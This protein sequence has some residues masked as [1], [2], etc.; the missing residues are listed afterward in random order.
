MILGTGWAGFRTLLDVDIDQY[1]VHVVSPRNH[2]LFTPLLTSTTVG[3]LEFR[4]VIGLF[5]RSDF[6]SHYKEPVRT[7]RKRMNYIQAA[8]TSIDPEKQIVHAESVYDHK[9]SFCIN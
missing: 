5:P 2:F 4:G 9:F 8:C 1:D 7:A 6:N 3:T